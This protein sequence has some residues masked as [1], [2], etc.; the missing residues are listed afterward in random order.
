MEIQWS[1]VA[2]T[3]LVGTGSWLFIFAG[4]D[5]VRGVIRNAKAMD[6]CLIAFFVM[7][8]CGGLASVTHLSHPDRMLAA[9]GH[10]TSGIFMEA[11]FVGLLCIVLIAF[12]VLK[13]REAPLGAMKALAIVGMLFGL[14]LSFSVGNSYIMPARPLWNTIALP[15]AYVGTAAACGA[16]ARLVVSAVFSETEEALSFDG[17]ALFVAS[18]VSL[19]TVLAYGIVSGVFASP[20]LVVYAALVVVVG[21][22][23]PLVLGL[24]VAKHMSSAR[25][26]GAVALAAVLIGAG[27][28]RVT[29]WLIGTGIENYFGMIF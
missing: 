22:L 14:V 15:L 16:A 18:L 19:I 13:R 21:S 10:P 29:M 26:M 27:A 28:F 23:M 4:L 5:Y 20:D 24:M 25:C 9:L 8:V 7:L 12:Y 6:V 11:L 1:L 2:F 17:K 3:L